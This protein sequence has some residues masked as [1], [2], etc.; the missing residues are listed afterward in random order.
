[1]VADGVSLPLK[2]NESHFIYDNMGCLHV[3][4]LRILVKL[5]CFPKLISSRWCKYVDGLLH[6][7]SASDISSCFLG[8]GIRLL[9]LFLLPSFKRW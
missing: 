8:G 1:V 6:K 7:F 5:L 9:S 2:L 4:Y 3:D